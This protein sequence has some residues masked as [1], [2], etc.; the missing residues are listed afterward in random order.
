VARRRSRCKVSAQEGTNVR[1]GFAAF[2]LALSAD[3]TSAAD[4]S[5]RIR[6]TGKLI[7]SNG[8]PSTTPIQEH[9]LYCPVTAGGPPSDICP[10]DHGGLYP[11]YADAYAG[12]APYGAHS[13]PVNHPG[14]QARPPSSPRCPAPRTKS[15]LTILEQTRHQREQDP[16]SCWAQRERGRGEGDDFLTLAL[17]QWEREIKMPP[18]L[19]S[20]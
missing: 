15:P 19:I 18:T 4:I 3:Y 1:E 20:R 17:A 5:F 6:G 9:N 7:L 2:Q 16:L 11:P 13:N 14:P 8:A 12:A 10:V